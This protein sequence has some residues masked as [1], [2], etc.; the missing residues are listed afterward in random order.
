MRRDWVVTLTILF[1]G[2]LLL[3]LIRFGTHYFLP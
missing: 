1:F 3:L 2:A